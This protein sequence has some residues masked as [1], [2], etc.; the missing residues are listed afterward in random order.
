M[1]WE[2]Y[3]K[4]S[5]E[6]LENLLVTWRKADTDPGVMNKELMESLMTLAEK[7]APTKILCAHSKPWITKEL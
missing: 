4:K 3:E 6:V 1:D 5:V 7:L 2:S